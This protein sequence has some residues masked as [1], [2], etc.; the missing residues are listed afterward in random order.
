MG[1]EL[2]PAIILVGRW[3]RATANPPPQVFEGIV[4]DLPFASFFLAKMLHGTPPTRSWTHHA[5]FSLSCLLVFVVDRTPKAGESPP[6][7]A[8]V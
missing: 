2:C 1:G 6:K 7:S 5:M 4:A 3:R 8:P